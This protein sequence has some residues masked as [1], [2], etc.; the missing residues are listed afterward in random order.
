M[1]P[2][3]A[4]DCQR[5]GHCHT[6]AATDL[7]AISDLYA[8]KATADLHTVSDLHAS[9][10]VTNVYASPDADSH[11][12]ILVD[13]LG[14][15]WAL[16]CGRFVGKREVVIKSLGDLLEEVPGVA[17]ATLVG[18]RCVLILDVPALVTR[19]ALPSRE[20]PQETGQKAE[21]ARPARVLVVDDAAA[22]RKA[23]RRRLEAAGYRVEEAVDGVEALA[24]AERETFDLISTDAVMPRMDGYELTRT[25]RSLDRY[26]DTPIVMVSAQGEKLDQV[27]GFDAGVDEYVV[28]PEDR[29]ELMRVVEER[30]R[31]VA[32]RGGGGTA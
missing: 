28:K 1:Y 5:N 4:R 15:S 2:T 21:V 13:L 23:I 18:D 17:G 25:L 6:T 26:A 3:H 9:N 27:R 20:R 7:H 31:Q 24:L 10:A 19:A 32:R 8:S 14:R 11:N 12:V 30:L 22:V 29:D 16:V